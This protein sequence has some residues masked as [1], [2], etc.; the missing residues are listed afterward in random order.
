VAL[1]IVQ[2][3]RQFGGSDLV[4]VKFYELLNKSMRASALSKFAQCCLI[5]SPHDYRT[6]YQVKL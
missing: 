3:A 5:S 6:S 4:T 2:G 1:F